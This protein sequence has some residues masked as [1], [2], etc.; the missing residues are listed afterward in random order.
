MEVDIWWEH[1]LAGEAVVEDWE[2]LVVRLYVEFVNKVLS[3]VFGHEKV[4]QQ[5]SVPVAVVFKE[6]PV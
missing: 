2:F 1:E 3:F 4:N 5:G 6:F